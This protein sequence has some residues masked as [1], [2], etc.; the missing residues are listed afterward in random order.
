L[1]WDD[2]GFH[3]ERPARNVEGDVVGHDLLRPAVLT[4]EELPRSHDNLDSGL[5]ADDVGDAGRAAREHVGRF[6]G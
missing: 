3:K 4:L 6:D 2:C 1:P 5:D